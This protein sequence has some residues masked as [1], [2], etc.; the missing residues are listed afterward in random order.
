MR[1]TLPAELADKVGALDPAAIEEVIEEAWPAVRDADELHDALLTLLWVPESLVTDW[2]LFLPALTQ[3]RRAT[4]LSVP[5][6]PEGRGQGEGSEKG[7]GSMK[8]EGRRQ[9]EEIAVNGLVA[10]ERL[11]HVL[12]VFPGATMNPS[13]GVLDEDTQ[14]SM[15]DSVFKIVQGWMECLGPI[16]ATE[17]ADK[18]HLRHSSIEQALLQLE[19]N[20]QVLRGRFRPIPPQRAMGDA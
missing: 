17:L 9:D 18:L 19:A 12:E 11:H 8:G 1:R 13:I 20:G 16:T 14:A 10:A 7:E 5:L 4:L 3:T 2:A 15:E 6:S